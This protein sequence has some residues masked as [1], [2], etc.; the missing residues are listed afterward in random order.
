MNKLKFYVYAYLRSKDSINGKRGTV[1]YVG[2]GSGNRAYSKHKGVSVPKDRNLIVFLETKLTE[3]GAFAIERRMICWYGRK[4]I[5]N[6][7]LVNRTDGGDGVA[8]R[9]DTNET[10]IK[11]SQGQTG[12]KHDPR[13]SEQKLST[14]SAMRGKNHSTKTKDRMSK[15]HAGV[16]KSS[17]MRAK[18][19]VARKGVRMKDTSKIK[20]GIS[21]LE[22]TKVNRVC[23]IETR[24][25]Y[26]IPNF[27]KHVINNFKVCH[28]ETR[29]EYKVSSFMRMFS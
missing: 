16:K 24:K 10:K 13:T 17:S 12:R 20:L 7:I 18:L 29:K 28:I 21:R 1:Y 25:E 15:A 4:D 26:D 8:G 27:I 9:K 11:K 2:K 22:S 14:G 5:N 19:S 23:C 3:F 6:G